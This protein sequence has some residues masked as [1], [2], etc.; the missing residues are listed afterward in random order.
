M[1]VTLAIILIHLGGVTFGEELKLFGA[2]VRVKNPDV[3]FDLILI[4][5]AYFVWR[6]YQY[7]HTDGAYSALRSQ[8]QKAVSL[9]LDR[10]LTNYIFKSLPKGVTLISGTYT[11]TNVARTTVINGCYEVNVEF[12]T[13]RGQEQSYKLIKAPQSIFKWQSIPIQLSFLF[14][15]RI[16]TDFY[17]PFSLVIYSLALNF[18]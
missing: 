6:F 18:V 15:G 14:R 8:Y 11:Y 2:S 5:Q 9:R 12:P 17:L 3:L 7:F 13:N 4:A 10:I 1:L 16:L